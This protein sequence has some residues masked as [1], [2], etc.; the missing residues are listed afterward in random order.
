MNHE[1]RLK[2]I[3]YMPKEASSF[4]GLDTLL[5]SARAKGDHVKREHVSQWLSDQYIY[6]VH[7][8]A[9]V[10]FK[11]NLTLVQDID[12]QWQADLVEMGQF[13]KFNNGMKYIL[14]CIDVLSKYACAVP[15]KNKM[16]QQVCAAFKRIFTQGC[17]PK[18]LQTDQGKEFLNHGFQ[19]LLKQYQIVHF[20]TNSKVKASVV[21]R[22]NRTIK[23]KMWTVYGSF[24]KSKPSKFKFK[25]GDHVRVSRIKGKFEKGY[26]QTF[27]DEIFIVKECVPGLRPIYKLKDYAGDDIKGQ[28]YTEELQKINT[29][30]DRV[31]RIQNILNSRGRVWNKQ[32]LFKWLGWG[33]KFNSWIKASEVKDIAPGVVRG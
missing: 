17:V 9:W 23:L 18:K 15:L 33:V 28:F 20:L 24:V 12:W 8:P 4:G 7:R 2:E 10:R 11:R 1:E 13:S 32:V 21:E 6:T 26:E 16:G 5:R 29:N 3:Y 14:T 31:Y 22:F 19:S 27:T 25:E 30:G